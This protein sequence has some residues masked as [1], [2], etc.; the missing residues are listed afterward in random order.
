MG[1]YPV[2]AELRAL[3]FRWF[4]PDDTSAIARFLAAPDPTL[5]DRE[6]RTRAASFLAR[7]RCATTS[8]RCSM[9]QDGCR[10]APP[11]PVDPVRARRQRIAHFAEL[12]QRLGYLLYGAAVVVFFLGFILGF[13]PGMGHV[14][15]HLH[16]RRS[17]LLAPAIVAGYAVKAAE[18]DDLEHGR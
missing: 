13:T 5:L 4:E 6:R 17:I 14:H 2:A 9:T 7:A 3:G 1:D 15:R 11:P 12:A 8:E 16:G 18:R 10:D